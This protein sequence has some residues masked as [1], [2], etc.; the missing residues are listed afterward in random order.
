MIRKDSGLGLGLG[1]GLGPKAM[2][3]CAGTLEEMDAAVTKAPN[4]NQNFIRQIY[5]LNDVQ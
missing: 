4:N 3:V 2:V 1:L 5:A